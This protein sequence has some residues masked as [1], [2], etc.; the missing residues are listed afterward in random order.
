[1]APFCT[2]R[3]QLLLL[4]LCARQA[5]LDEAVSAR[6]S[7]SRLAED[8]QEQID[9]LR[10]RAKRKEEEITKVS[11]PSRVF[12]LFELTVDLRIGFACVPPLS[13]PLCVPPLSP[14]HLFIV[15][16]VFLV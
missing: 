5:H 4:D 13:Y 1:M 7:L 3:L 15:D 9:R 12:V 11:L 8:Q 16:L 10:R 14:I 2:W 6:D